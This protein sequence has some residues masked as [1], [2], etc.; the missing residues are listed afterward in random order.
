MDPPD[1]LIQPIWEISPHPIALIRLAGDP[2]L[3]RYAYV[4]PAFCETTGYSYAEAVGAPATLL[5]GAN[6]SLAGIHT[7]EAVIAQG[8]ASRVALTQYRKNKSEYVANATIAPLI[9]PDGDARYIIVIETGIPPLMPALDVE[10]GPGTIVPMVLPVPLR[11]LPAGVI[12]TH[13]SSHPDLDAVRALW[14]E[15]RGNR[16]LPRRAEFDLITMLR[17]AP[18]LSVVTVMPR[19]RLQYRLFGTDLAR[20]YGQDLTG[21]F[22]DELTPKDLWSVVTAHYQEVVR[23]RQPLFAPISICNG[24]WYCEVSRL[25][26]PVAGEGR[27]DQVAFVM[28]VDYQ[29]GE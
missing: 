27:S 22:L 6:T 21:H 8:V 26:L 15:T 12:P 25:L 20:V 17:W 23:T 4:N 19:G 5:F 28:G 13:L 9:D 2:R 18:H 3:R 11:E 10:A 1:I 7:Y 14:M 16:A 29:R 24:R